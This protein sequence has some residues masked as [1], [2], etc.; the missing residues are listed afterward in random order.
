MVNVS[1]LIC[2]IEIITILQ[3]VRGDQIRTLYEI[4]NTCLTESA[5]N[6]WA[7]LSLSFV[8]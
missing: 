2:K 4:L 8:L 1:F 3:S 7:L 5:Q 6:I